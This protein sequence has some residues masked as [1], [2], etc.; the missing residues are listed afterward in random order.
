[1]GWFRRILA[2]ARKIQEGLAF[3]LLL[4][5]YLLVIGP[6]HYLFLLRR[7]DHSGSPWGPMARRGRWHEKERSPCTPES[8][9]KPY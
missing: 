9:R 5:S 6:Y 2:V 1:M 8:L 3:L 7:K 4:L